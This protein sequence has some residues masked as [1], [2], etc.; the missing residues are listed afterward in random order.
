MCKKVFLILFSIFLLGAIVSCG[1]SSDG[2]PPWHSRGDLT[3][4]NDTSLSISK[5]YLTPAN[6]ST[7]GPDQLSS[8]L[9]SGESYTIT[10]I[11]PDIYDVKAVIIG[12]LSTYYGYIYD[13][14]IEARHTFDLY[15]YNSDFSGSLEIVN[16]DT[17]GSYIDA[18][19]VSPAGSGSWGPNQLESSI[20]PG[21][22]I[23]LYD[24]S[25]DSYDVKIVW[26]TI[27]YDVYYYDN[28]IKS[29]T[30]LTLNA[31]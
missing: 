17:T 22:S 20:A 15:A 6:E 25:P 28:I 27:P 5:L 26:D 12:N 9:L 19:Y 14:P 4:Y 8:D 1:R 13:I 11:T 3:L 18:I 30:L 7:W 16:N 2:G 29:L 23:H 24:L 31:N 10:D 21:D